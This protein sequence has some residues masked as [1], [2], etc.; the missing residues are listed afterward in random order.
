MVKFN[1]AEILNGM[2]FDSAI[3]KFVAS[4]PNL[5]HLEVNNCT[6]FIDSTFKE[7]LTQSKSLKFLDLNGIPAITYPIFEELKEL[8]PDLMIKRYAYQVADP[9]DNGLRVPR[10]LIAKKKKSKKKKSKKKKK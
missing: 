8:R 9:K 4:L 2:N 3:I 1:G 7:I 5:E 6:G 10:R